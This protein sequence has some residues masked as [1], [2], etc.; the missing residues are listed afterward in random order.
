MMSS[1]CVT[2]G[3]KKN[4]Q[5]LEISSFHKVVN[6]DRTFLN[7]CFHND[8]SKTLI[9]ERILEGIISRSL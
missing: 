6:D 9:K 4:L 2:L 7:S 1:F 8:Q 3:K 5:I